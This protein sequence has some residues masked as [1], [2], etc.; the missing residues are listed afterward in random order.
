MDFIFEDDNR[1]VP[2]KK[3]KRGLSSPTIVD[4]PTKKATRQRVATSSMDVDFER[5]IER[6]RRK[7]PAKVGYLKGGA[8]RFIS[9][10][11][12]SFNFTLSLYSLG[13]ILFFLL[14]LRLVL[15]DRGVI[16]YYEKE[17][18]I[19]AK[20]VQLHQV[21][22]ENIAIVEEIDKI[23]SVPSYQKMLAREHLGVIAKYEYLI[24]F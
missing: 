12:F 15:M 24:L 13:W 8:S 21:E 3:R 19:K 22:Q 9:L 1:I 11:K 20:Q 7:A 16:D 14:C 6:R 10:P 17:N 4:N 18:L 5:P 2:S 23:K